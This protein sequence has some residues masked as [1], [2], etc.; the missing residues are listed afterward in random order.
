MARES[1]GDGAKRGDAGT[2]NGAAGESATQVAATAVSAAYSKHTPIRTKDDIERNRE[3]ISEQIKSV[4][5]GD[6]KKY[7]AEIERKTHLFE[8]K[9]R[10]IDAVEGLKYD[11][12][13][14][15]MMEGTYS[16]IKNLLI[17]RD[18]R[19]GIIT[20]EHKIDDGSNPTLI[21]D[22]R[23]MSSQDVE[24]AKQTSQDAYGISAIN[25]AQSALMMIDM[26]GASG[27]EERKKI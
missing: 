21:R 27:D 5:T 2:S 19:N 8:S 10:T 3:A 15:K 20:E 25:N 23:F 13:H 6:H 18:A 22:A 24:N 12:D 17:L 1:G 11:S 16:V 14:K 4:I 7:E 26:I 9:E